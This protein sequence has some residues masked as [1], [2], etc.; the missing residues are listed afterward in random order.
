VA[1]LAACAVAAVT[2]IVASTATVA[3]SRSTPSSSSVL[4]MVAL[5]LV[6]ALFSFTEGRSARLADWPTSGS[7]GAIASTP[8]FLVPKLLQRPLLR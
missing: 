3:A 7:S 2:R 1:A 5:M 6:S 4:G 8:R